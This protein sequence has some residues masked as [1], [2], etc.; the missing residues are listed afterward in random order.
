MPSTLSYPGV[1]VE[2][3]P[4]GVRTISGVATSVT[5]FIGS[6]PRGPVNE[7]VRVFNYGDVERVFGGVAAASEASYAIQ[8]FFLNGGGQAYV[9]RVTNTDT[10]AGRTRAVA[11][12]ITAQDG[13]G[14]DAMTITAVNPG[15]WG[16]SVRVEVDYNTP[17]P[18][19]TFNMTVLEME[20]VEGREQPVRVETF[21][22]LTPDADLAAR[23]AGDSQ[24]IRLSNVATT[25]AR[26]PQ[27]TG[28]SSSAL[29]DMSTLT[30][31]QIMEVTPQGAAGTYTVTLD[32]TTI[33]RAS[34]LAGALQTALRGITPTGADTFDL[35]RAT[36]QLA[37][38]PS[39]EQYL[40]IRA[41]GATDL[42]Q[43]GDPDAANTLASDVGLD[44]GENVQRYVLGSGTAAGAQALPGG[45]Q[46]AGVDGSLPG[47]TDLVGSDAAPRTG[48]YALRT[49]DLFNI[50]SVPDTVRLGDTEAGQVFAAATTLCEEKRAFYLLDMPHP[51]A[52]PRDQVAEVEAWLGD[53][54]QIR[55]RNVALYYPRPQVADP[56]NDFRLRPVAP[57]G[58]IAGLYARTDT[59]R[60][61]WKAPAGTEAVL[62]GVQALEYTLTDGENGVLNPQGVNCLRTLPTFGRVA[63]GARTL[64]GADALAS[65]WKYVPVRRLALYLEES[66]FRG[67]HWVVFEPNDEPLWGSIRLN[68]G[69]FMNTL[70]RQGAFQ[71]ASPR[72]AY[73][74][75]CDASTTTQTDINNG[76]VNVLVGFAPLKPAEFVVLKIQQ[77]AGQI[78]T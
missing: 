9:V 40:L 71:G 52:N 16:N 21:R 25:P 65:E 70:F 37:G 33:T 68:V 36:V 2:E 4:S 41:G 38:D 42:L 6:F 51:A 11:A 54:G 10:S 47:A 55:H 1:Y 12:A 48:M 58:T 35:S 24:L 75:R 78:D 66:L 63:W 23:V 57:S 59:E 73:F 17:T 22:N 15:V 43:F 30:G 60:G 76:I 50:L 77:M 53:N 14:N 64:V 31:T 32:L 72:E 74:V 56:L 69:A 67:L 45:A 3:I 29:P 13:T 26:R 5:A 8:Q 34:A 18:T 19:T 39:A 49:V 61:V 62:R 27:Q 46:V 44:V 20:T 28:T 7:A